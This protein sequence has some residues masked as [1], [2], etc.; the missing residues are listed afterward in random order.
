MEERSGAMAYLAKL[1]QQNVIFDASAGK[2][3]KR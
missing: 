1:R 3:R 2:R